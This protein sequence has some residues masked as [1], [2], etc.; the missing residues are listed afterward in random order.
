MLRAATQRIFR[1]IVAPSLG[2]PRA[3]GLVAA[4]LLLASCAAPVAAVKPTRALS[5]AVSIDKEANQGYPVAV[6]LVLVYGQMALTKIKAMPARQW[7]DERSQLARD[8]PECSGF[9]AYDWEWV[10]DR[11]VSPITVMIP[12]DVLEVFTFANYLAKGDHRISVNVAK[13]MNLKLTREAAEATPLVDQL[14]KQHTTDA[15][16]RV[17][18]RRC[19]EAED[20]DPTRP[21]GQIEDGDAAPTP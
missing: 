1:A 10:P 7:F 3:L 15:R 12:P 14:L 16:R 5:V 9:V 17:Y 6:S 19:D 21:A 18:H 8:F 13:G 11:Y 4:V 20:G 2:A